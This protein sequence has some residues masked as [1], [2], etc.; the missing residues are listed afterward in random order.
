MTPKLWVIAVIGFNLT[1]V[2]AQPVKDY[3]LCNVVQKGNR[4]ASTDGS[5]RFEV[6]IDAHTVSDVRSA[7]VSH[8]RRIMLLQD[9]SGSLRKG[10]ASAISAEA[11]SD[12]SAVTSADDQLGLVDFNDQY[13]LDITL[14]DA[15]AFS[16]R[17]NDPSF[18]Q[19]IDY[20]GGTALFD[21]LVATASYLG[22]NPQEGD[23]IIV[24][25]DGGDNASYL[26]AK[27]TREKLLAARIRVY[28]L[29][30]PGIESGYA[31]S[32]P[33]AM[34]DIVR[35][36]GGTT[37]I[38]DSQKDSVQGWS[39]TVYNLIKRPERID[40]EVSPAVLSPVRLNVA[41]SQQDGGRGP[42]LELVCPRQ[43]SASPRVQ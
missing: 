12:L 32:T 17:Y 8:P 42:K 21:A 24:I 18:Q 4:D 39:Q 19:R 14:R 28:M 40:F 29:V 41:V 25:S 23:S 22:E 7:P 3:V 20:R 1:T 36:T 30:L 27:V 9:L 38:A 11:I 13:F 33:S 2:Y 43:L 37:A 15:K 34:L 5:L 10:K 16:Q 31:R 6:K 26:N 35:E